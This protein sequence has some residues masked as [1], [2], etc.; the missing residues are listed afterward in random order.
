MILTQPLQKVNKIS[1]FQQFCVSLS[2]YFV[3]P[4]N[5][6]CQVSELIHFFSHWATVKPSQRDMGLQVCVTGEP[7]VNGDNPQRLLV[8]ADG[9]TEATPCCVRSC[10]KK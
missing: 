2:T 4:L 6:S 10:S 7:Q 9:V 8:W 1:T 3:H 5:L